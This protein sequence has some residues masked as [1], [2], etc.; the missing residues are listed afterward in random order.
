MRHQLCGDLFTFRTELKKVVI[1]IAKQLYG[2]FP[3][4]GAMHKDAR[5]VAD[6]ASKL[7]KS[8]DYL[9]F[10][11]SSEVSDCVL[12]ASCSIDFFRAST[13]I[14]SRKFSRMRALIFFMAIAKKH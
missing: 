6:A 4:G 1:S 3:K 10:P 9:R 5:H 13:R 11:D 14:S 12:A 7:I 8:G 2:V